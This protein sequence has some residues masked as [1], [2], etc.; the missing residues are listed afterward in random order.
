MKK[1]GMILFL[2]AVLAMSP[3]NAQ[4]RSSKNMTIGILGMG[5]IQLLDTIPELEIGPGGGV[6]FDYRFNQRFSITIDAWATTHGGEGPSSA[7][8]GIEFMGI[9]TFTIKLYFMDDETSKW[10]PFAGLGIGVFALSEGTIENGT[11]G[12]GLGGQLEVGFDYYFSDV[13][14]AGFSGVFR[15]TGI[16]NSLSNTGGSNATAI[17]PFSLVGRVGFHF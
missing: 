14:S 10:D 5:N 7:D 9:P 12:V 1:I 15:S 13:I 2:L 4:A 8:N 3:G 17:I 11:N 6:Y 16:I